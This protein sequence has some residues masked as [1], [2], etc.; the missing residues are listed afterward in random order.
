MHPAFFYLATLL[1]VAYA[2][3]FICE[4]NERTSLDKASSDLRNLQVNMVRTER[5]GQLAQQVVRRMAVD[6][7]QDP[8]LGELLKKYGVTVTFN[9]TQAAPASGPGQADESQKT[10]RDSS[11]GPSH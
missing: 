11:A 1:S 7:A 5:S 9:E 3:I 6:S 2:A 4:A 8:A 10:S